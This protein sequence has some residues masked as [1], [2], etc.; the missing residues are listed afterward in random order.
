MNITSL[1]YFSELA[2]D[3]HMTRTANRLFISQQTLSNHIQ[4]LEGYYGV[5]LFHRRPS[6]SLTYAGEQVLAFSETVLNAHTNLKDILSD[7]GQL[8]RG[9]LR[10]GASPLRTNTCLSVILPDFCAR[11][12][13]VEIRVTNSF[14]AKLEPLVVDGTLDCAIILSHGPNPKLTEYPLINEQ[15]YL[16]ISE[17]LLKRYYGDETEALKT[18]SMH[19]ANAADFVRL[20][21]CVYDNRLGYKLMACFEDGKTPTPYLTSEDTRICSSTC[22]QG[23]AA[24][25]ATQTLLINRKNDIPDDLNIFPV[26]L[27]GVPVTEQLSLIFHKD[28]YLSHYSRYFLELLLQHFDEMEH[29]HL[30]RKV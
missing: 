15:V 24:C 12:P 17:P 18:K 19:G 2:K 16:C 6:L 10:F 1:Y 14:S 21:F 22:F 11:Y 9:V 29:I 27:Q 7:I 20:P 3:P 4:R 26:H 13:Q 5:Q 30:E 25:F 28:R 8:E 23:L